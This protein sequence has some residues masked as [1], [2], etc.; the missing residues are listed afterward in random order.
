M[1]FFLD[2]ACVCIPSADFVCRKCRE[3]EEAE[4]ESKGERTERDVRDAIDLT[5]WGYVRADQ[6]GYDGEVVTPEEHREETFFAAAL[7]LL[8]AKPIET[9]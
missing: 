7:Q 5:G 3:K 6:D 4:A 2:A 1:P 8:G 9:K